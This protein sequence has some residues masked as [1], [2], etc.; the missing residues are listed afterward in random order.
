MS[1]RTNSG[2]TLR[3]FPENYLVKK[4]EIQKKES[5]KPFFD[6]KE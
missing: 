1:I 3:T 5:Q 2:C 4:Q 6:G